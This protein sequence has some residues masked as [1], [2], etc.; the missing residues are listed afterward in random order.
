MWSASVSNLL[1]LQTRL[2]LACSSSAEEQDPFTT[3]HCTCERA[4]ARRTF[5]KQQ[6]EKHNTLL[7]LPIQSMWAEWKL[8]GR[9]IQLN[10]FSDTTNILH[11]HLLPW[12]AKPKTP[13]RYFTQNRLKTERLCVWFACLKTCS[14]LFIPNKLQQTATI[15]KDVTW[16]LTRLSVREIQIFWNLFT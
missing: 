10:C 15:F 14:S 7:V 8:R 11:R 9:A 2:R 6:H 3:Q 4:F 12:M 16:H 1:Y 13:Q 5:S